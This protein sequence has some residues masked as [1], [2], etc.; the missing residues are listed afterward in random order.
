MENSTYVF[1]EERVL[2]TQL[3]EE[4]VIYDIKSNEYFTL[5]ETLFLIADGIKNQQS[6][7]IILE[8]LL[9]EYDITEEVCL[10]EI[11]QGI[12]QLL[13]KQIILKQ[14]NV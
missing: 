2:L 6:I 12:Q 14:T 11:H 3:G 9:N 4:G 1:N 8:K 13:D 10:A 7:S 5:N